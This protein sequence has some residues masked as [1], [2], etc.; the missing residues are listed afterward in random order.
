MAK[1]TV[2]Q[3]KEPVEFGKETVTEVTVTRKLKHLRGCVVKVAAE[4]GGTLTLDFDVL[5]NLASKMIGQPP[6]FLDEMGEADQSHILQEANDFL[7]TR[8][9]P[10]NLA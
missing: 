3:L 9:G 4:D 1:E 8:L 10:G 7:L 6:A 2:Y 5:I